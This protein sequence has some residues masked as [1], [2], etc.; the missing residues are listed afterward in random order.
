M[1]FKKEV[2]YLKIKAR[3]QEGSDQRLG[4]LCSSRRIKQRKMLDFFFQVFGFSQKGTNKKV[5][6]L[7]HQN[8]S[9]WKGQSTHGCR[10]PIN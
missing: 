8:P 6:H 9:V 10:S 4:G 1:P 2:L 3:P 7:R 5:S